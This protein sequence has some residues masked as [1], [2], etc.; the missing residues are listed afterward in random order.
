MHKNAIKT[1]I[2][3]HLDSSSK[4]ILSSSLPNGL[5][6]SLNLYLSRWFQVRFFSIVEVHKEE[7]KKR[8][9]K[10][11]HKYFVIWYRKTITQKQTKRRIFLYKKRILIKAPIKQPTNLHEHNR[12]KHNQPTHTIEHQTD[13]KRIKSIK[14]VYLCQFFSCL[15]FNSTH[16]NRRKFSDRG[17]DGCGWQFERGWEFFISKWGRKIWI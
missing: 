9:T 3:V 7:K 13:K 2:Y 1:W 4:S 10:Q 11:K 8:V 15:I 16:K 6:K 17:I 14:I 5:V 12:M